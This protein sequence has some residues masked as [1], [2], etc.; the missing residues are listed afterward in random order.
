MF[1]GYTV[2]KVERIFDRVRDGDYKSAITELETSNLHKFFPDALIDGFCCGLRSGD[3][4]C[5]REL[6]LDRAFISKD[7][8]LLWMA[9]YRQLR[10]G[11]RHSA[12]TGV[13]GVAPISAGYS[14][15][16][17]VARSRFGADFHGGA[18]IIGFRRV[19]CFGLAGG[20]DGEAFLVPNN[21]EIGGVA[22]GP[23]INDMSEQYARLRRA[24]GMVRRFVFGSSA[25]LI[26][27]PVLDPIHGAS[28]QNLEFQYHEVA[29][30]VGI[31]FPQKLKIG[32]FRSFHNCAVEEWRSDGISFSLMAELLSDDQRGRMV[33]ANLALRLSV[34][35][36]RIGG[37]EADHDAHATAL[38]L[39]DLIDSG[40]ATIDGGQLHLSAQSYAE[41]PDAVDAQRTQ[42]WQTTRMEIKDG[43]D[44]GALSDIYARIK[45]RP[46][47]A[48]KLAALSMH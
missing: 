41:L 40:A 38:T 36:L 1:D 33:A 9:P 23:A 43:A 20:R 35:A 2:R 44:C 39:Q 28:T 45:L 48:S 30:G 37:F 8:M 18:E 6:F 26:L 17:E 5:L 14:A 29:H 21:W 25:D 27:A 22:D 12:I 19:A 46:E 42:A 16:K 13:L 11:V 7:G 32:L 24:E 10:N 15:I 47:T 3:W 4:K 34:D 31:G